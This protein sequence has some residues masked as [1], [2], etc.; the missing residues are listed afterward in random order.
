MAHLKVFRLFAAFEVMFSFILTLSKKT[1]EIELQKRTPYPFIAFLT[2]ASVKRHDAGDNLSKNGQWK[3]YLQMRLPIR[4]VGF[5]ASPASV[6]NQPFILSF[7]QFAMHLF[8]V[9]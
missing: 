6:V 2:M 1:R 5:I 8:Q 3:P 4:K 9:R 7:Q